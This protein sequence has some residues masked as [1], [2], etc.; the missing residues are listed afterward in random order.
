MT[1]STWTT[2]QGLPQNF[3]TAIDQTPDGF[4]WI[5]TKG[6]L[7]R[8]DG[9]NFRTSFANELPALHSSVNGLTHDA[10][11]RLWVTTNLGFLY[12]HDGT[13]TQITLPGKASAQ[14]GHLVISHDATILVGIGDAVWRFNPT[15]QTFSPI[16]GASQNIRGY[17]EDR[18]GTVWLTDSEAVTAINTYGEKTRYPL[19]NASIIITA[20]NDGQI[21]A[22][23]GHKV[24]HFDGLTFVP[25]ENA[26]TEESVDM[27]VTRD[28]SLWIAAGGLEGLSR[29]N[30]SGV[31]RFGLHEGLVSNDVRSLFEDRDGAMWIGT[32]SGL[33]RLR[34]GAFVAY[35]KRDGL[36]GFAP[37]YDAIFEAADKSIWTGTLQDGISVFRN[38]TWKTFGPEVGVRRGQ[39]RGFVEDGVMPIVA[40]ADYGLF[41]WNGKK[42][43]K[44]PGLPEGYITSPLRTAD[45]SIWFIIVRQG[46][47]RLHDGKLDHFDAA[48][49]L[50]D[51]RVWCLLPD[52]N[53]GLWAGANTGLF[54]LVNNRWTQEYPAFHGTVFTL[55]YR[56][57]GEL[58]AGTTTGVVVFSANTFKAFGRKEGLLSD[59]VLQLVE[60]REHDIWIA[61]AAGL[62]SID[63]PQLDNLLSGR[64]ATLSPKLFTD[65]DGLPGRDLLPVSHVL[66]FLATD[67]RLWF[68]MN[69]GPIAGNQ[70]RD[71]APQAF[72]DDILVDGAIQ[73]KGEINVRPGRHRLTFTFTAP[74]FAAPELLHFRYR[75]TN[76]DSAWIDAGQQHE[77]SYAGL[78]PGTYSFEV[79]AIG[80]G[81]NIGPSARVPSINLAP[82]FWQ[83]RSFIFLASILA[84]ALI[85]ELTRRRTMLRARRMSLL[86][87]ERAAERERIAYQIHDTVIQDLIGATLYLEIAEMELA[88]G[89]LDPSKPLEG[90]AAR[91]RESIA[92]SRSM[93]SNLH[94]TAL[95]EY[96]LLDVLRLAEAEFRLGASPTFSLTH[97][98]TVRDVDPLLRDE[99]YRI[100]RE[101]IANAFRHANA[102]NI[103]VRAGFDHHAL[104]VEISDDG[105][106]MDDML[107]QTGRAGH[108]GLHA[109]RAHGE[110]IGAT[111]TINSAPGQGTTIRLMTRSSLRTRVGSSMRTRVRNLLQNFKHRVSPRRK[112]L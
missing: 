68:A 72:A 108:F 76:W 110:R 47:Y 65:S 29:K 5:G 14:P 60:D 95:P 69:H 22:G 46:V 50:T 39:V 59:P 21:Y 41:R 94:S 19:H 87:Q 109:M 56:S 98:G 36:T 51:P 26:G 52:H 63:P 55:A 32:I 83:T 92:R 103:T 38:G 100:C 25:I 81:G 37:Q 3:I 106:G 67:G 73:P 49:G 18:N 54:H 112:I 62:S 1:L 111:L 58:L 45:D 6:G 28:G 88:S 84:I 57:F 4:L 44:L 31:Q 97:T 78:P 13:W 101:A 80:R 71:P 64:N 9:V 43:A 16:P 99:V 40:I 48:Q 86:F 75:L 91:L 11:G 105:A 79:Q 107:Q 30:Q 15:T 2:A 8:F 20:A 17:T 33:Q 82:Y 74:S 96:G 90:L 23:D 102:K 93:V 85:V 70:M 35:S 7:A 66:G 53:G 77:A 89:V 42:Y 61:T 104:S 34:R 10:A 12:E 24:F 27:T